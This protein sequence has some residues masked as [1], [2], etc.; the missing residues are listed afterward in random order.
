[1]YVISANNEKTVSRILD[2]AEALFA[3]H[4]YEAASFRGITRKAGVNLAAAHY[5]LGDKKLLYSMVLTR[6]LHR[7]N[8]L[9]LAQLDQAERVSGGA[10]VPLEQ[11][12]EIMARPLFECGNEAGDGSAHFL[13]LLG[14]SLVEPLPF[15]DELVTR[16]FQPVTARFAQAIRRHLIN[17]PPEEFLWRLSFV[18]GSMHHCL[19]TL[20]GMKELTRGICRNHDHASALRHF[21]QFAGAALTAPAGPKTGPVPA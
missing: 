9:R 4:G 7:I 15:M 3:Q 16:E 17:L 10:A 18:I 13:R 8:A 2:A 5:H 11:I 20:H 6:R 19:A 14:R 12:I 1:M 21:I